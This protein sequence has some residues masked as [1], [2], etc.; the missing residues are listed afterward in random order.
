MNL[1]IMYSQ[2]RNQ[3]WQMV[4]ER[5]GKPSAVLLFAGLEEG[6]A[7]FWQDSTFYYLTGIQ[8]P[9]WVLLIDEQ[10]TSHLYVPQTTIDRSVWLVVTNPDEIDQLSGP[11]VWH[12]LGEPDTSYTLSWYAPQACYAE[13]I[14]ALHNYIAK[15]VQLVGVNRATQLHQNQREFLDKISTFLKISVENFADCSDIISSLRRRKDAH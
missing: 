6:R 5:T 11:Y 4:Q 9:G 1:K 7:A 13:L 10:G 15:G 8:E 12:P 2:R 3:L 14:A